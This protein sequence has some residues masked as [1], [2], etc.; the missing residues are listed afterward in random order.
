MI[1]FYN[2]PKIVNFWMKNTFIPLEII[3]INS[4]QKIISIK[5][6][7]PF[8]KKNISSDLPVI[9]VIE[10]PKNC[11]EKIGMK[12]G[13]K[14]SWSKIKYKKNSKIYLPCIN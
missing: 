1:F 9:A 5:N 6:G 12:V 7:I 10:V 4:E 3:F 14:L 11:S 2:R 13:D 8:S